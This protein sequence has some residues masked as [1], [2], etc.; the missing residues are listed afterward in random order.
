MTIELF[1]LLAMLPVLAMV[2]AI[3]ALLHEVSRDE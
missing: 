1:L 3:L 2:C